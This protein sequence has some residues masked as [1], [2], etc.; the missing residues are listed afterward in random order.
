MKELTRACE[1]LSDQIM[2]VMTR[3]QPQF[4]QEKAKQTPLIMELVPFKGLNGETMDD[5]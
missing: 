2:D 5:F 4:D 3:V 1:P